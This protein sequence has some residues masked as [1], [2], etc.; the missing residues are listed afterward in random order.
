M[1]T[2]Y[3]TSG[4][5]GWL[6]AGVVGAPIC[7]NNRLMYSLHLPYGDSSFPKE[8]NGDKFASSVALPR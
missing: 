5:E 2:F 8:E 6:K 3:T 4:K 1:L 7:F